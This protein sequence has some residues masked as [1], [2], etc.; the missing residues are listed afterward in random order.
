MFRGELRELLR[1]VC[2]AGGRLLSTRLTV[3]SDGFIGCPWLPFIT[4]MPRM[5]HFFT[6]RAGG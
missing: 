6:E 3:E 2:S 5:L 4:Y 1:V